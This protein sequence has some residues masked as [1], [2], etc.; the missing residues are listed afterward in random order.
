MMI[1]S[2]MVTW[3]ALVICVFVLVFGVPVLCAITPY[4]MHVCVQSGL[5]N[6]VSKYTVVNC[7]VVLASDK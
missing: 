7:M 3:E 5:W 1:K 2:N 6:V 4:Y